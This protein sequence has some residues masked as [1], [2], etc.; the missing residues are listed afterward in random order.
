LLTTQR[1]QHPTDQAQINAKTYRRSLVVSSQGLWENAGHLQGT[2]SVEI[3]VILLVQEYGYSLSLFS[4]S[5][6]PELH[7][8][9]I[10]LSERI[11]RCPRFLPD[12]THAHT[13]MSMFLPIHDIEQITLL[14][15]RLV[16]SKQV[17]FVVEILLERLEVLVHFT[18][19]I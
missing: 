13:N 16:E 10:A 7:A 3:S 14:R 15:N 1:P 11:I 9:S 5:L 4:A 12:L 18:C 17:Q 6:C 19:H 8:V 2:R